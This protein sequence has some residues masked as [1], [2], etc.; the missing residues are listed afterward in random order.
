[1]HKQIYI[2]LAIDDMQKSQAFFK[3]LGFTFNP[4]F[5]NDQGAC[6]V[7]GD[8]IYAMLL[9]KDFFQGFTDKPLVDAALANEVLIALSCESRAEVDG[10]IA[11]ALAAGAT[12]PRPPQ[13][14]GFMYA[15]AFEDLDGHIWE[16]VYMEPE[17]AAGA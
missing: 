7:I 12:T 16:L 11:R 3:S 2:N 10:L 5:T 15:H 6:M 14:H 17:E 1:M 8:N 9:T 4:K 13:D